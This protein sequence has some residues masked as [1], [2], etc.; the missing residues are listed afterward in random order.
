MQHLEIWIRIL[1]LMAGT[2]VLFDT[3][4]FYK[5]YRHS[6][7]KTM[8]WC[9]LFLNLGFLTGAVSEYILVNLFENKLVF[10]ASPYG[11]IIDP[12]S[13]IFFV[14]L[15]Y[16]LI[17][18]YRGF[19]GKNPPPVFRPIFIGAVVFVALRTITSLIWDFPAAAVRAINV[20]NLCVTV[21]AF[22]L[23]VGALGLMAFRSGRVIEDGTKA[24]MARYFGLF[25]LGLCALLLV[26]AT[27]AGAYQSL[28]FVTAG[29]LFNTYPFIWYRRYL[30]ALSNSVSSVAA[31][32][33]FSVVYDKYGISVRQRE[34]IELILNGK[35]NRDIADKLFIAQH[36]VKNHIYNLYQKLG[37]KS[38]FE[39]IDFFLKAGDGSTE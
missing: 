14:G 10:K 34:I 17:F 31:R 18:L 5:K 12:F 15:T 9:C 6:F 7:L 19:Q 28:I 29:L 30:P 33:D 22:V 11:E 26:T 39:L 36:T 1:A 24:K 23:L 32:T 37:V 8:W 25:Y 16:F 27:F 20:V 4:R 13:S 35:S 2:G 38:R 21:S 3:H